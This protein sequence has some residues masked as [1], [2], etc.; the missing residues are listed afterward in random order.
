[1]RKLAFKYSMIPYE[2]YFTKTE[3]SKLEK[4]ETKWMAM[5]KENKI[6][7]HDYL[8]P[9]YTYISDL[10]QEDKAEIE[11]ERSTLHEDKSCVFC[12]EG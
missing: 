5:R 11:N 10:M 6:E 3:R 12:G 8:E 7:G 9:P 1:M 2:K 4:I